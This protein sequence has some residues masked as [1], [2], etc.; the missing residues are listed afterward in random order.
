MCKT[1]Y[2]IFLNQIKFGP[3]LLYYRDSG[4]LTVGS[5]WDS[6]PI[7]KCNARVKSLA[8]YA[9]QRCGL[10][11]GY[12]WKAH[13]P[14][15]SKGAVALSHATLGA[16]ESEFSMPNCIPG[17]NILPEWK[18]NQDILKWM[19]TKRI[20]CQQIYKWGTE[21]SSSNDVMFDGLKKLLHW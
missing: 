8:T 17:E 3:E 4:K 7:Y 11:S 16:Q 19:E 14:L 10:H 9:F 2:F 12:P 15:K 5:Y 1:C 6:L 21:G 20:C 18:G 13:D